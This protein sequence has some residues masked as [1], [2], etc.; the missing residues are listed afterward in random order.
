[1][2]SRTLQVSEKDIRQERRIV[3][4]SYDKYK[5]R[6]YSKGNK[7]SLRFLSF[8]EAIT[9]ARKG[10]GQRKKT[11]AIAGLFTADLSALMKKHE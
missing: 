6:N 1:M 11:Q 9:A 5:G 4:P 8:A 7:L 3:W 2:A 10:K